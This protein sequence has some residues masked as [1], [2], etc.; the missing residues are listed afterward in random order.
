MTEHRNFATY[1]N[2]QK[3]PEVMHEPLEIVTYAH[4]CREV[5]LCRGSGQLEPCMLKLP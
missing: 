4:V 2:E 3:K 1:I 5:V